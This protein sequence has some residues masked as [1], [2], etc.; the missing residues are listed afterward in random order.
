MESGVLS[1]SEQ[2]GDVYC[3]PQALTPQ[4]RP[5]QVPALMMLPNVRDP[6]LRLLLTSRFHKWDPE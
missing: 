5:V 3:A 4:P 2:G 6:D 1:V